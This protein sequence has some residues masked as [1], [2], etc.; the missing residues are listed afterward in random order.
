[1]IRRTRKPKGRGPRAV[2]RAVLRLLVAVAV[3]VAP[4]QAGARYFYC[5]AL[6]MLAFDPCACDEHEAA[7]CPAP[8]VERTR[9]DCCTRIVMPSVPEGVRAAGE[10]VP[11]P[12]VV[13]VVPA[14]P[15]GVDALLRSAVLRPDAQERRRP[16]RPPGRRRAQ[17]MVFLT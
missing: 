15:P 1:M 10:S 14:V 7:Q 17:L 11:P 5:E 8:S 16:P 13:A 4:L 6:G 2:V 12:E 9:V 3:L